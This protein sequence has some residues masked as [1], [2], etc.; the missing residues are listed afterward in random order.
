[1]DRAAFEAL[2]HARADSSLQNFAEE[3]VHFFRMMIPHHSQ[4]LEMSALARDRTENRSI[5][6]LAA[7]IEGGQAEE[8]ERMRGWLRHRGLAE[9]E[10]SSDPQPAASLPANMG[11]H[12]HGAPGAAPSN[13]EVNLM[14]GLLTSAE[15]AELAAAE[16]IEF[17]RLFLSYMIYHHRGAIQMVDELFA[18]PNGGKDEEVFRFA[19]EI[20]VDQSTE[21][22]RMERMSSL[23][24]LAP[25][26]P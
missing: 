7:R 10:E 23:S 4:A 15:M 2:F 18:S 8:I 24:A 11:G 20:R 16:G 14:P 1:M 12:D 26:T 25:A 17:D 3:D 5:L 21:V 6:A 9:P 13:P 19:A 22:A